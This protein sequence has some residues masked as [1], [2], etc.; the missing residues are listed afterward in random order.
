LKQLYQRDGSWGTCAQM[1][2]GHYRFIPQIEKVIPKV[3]SSCCW[4]YFFY[5]M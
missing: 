5:C 2:C 3:V 4:W 1:I